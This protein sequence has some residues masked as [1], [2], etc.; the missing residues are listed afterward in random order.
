MRKHRGDIGGALLVSA[1]ACV[2]AA[3][4]LAA[5]HDPTW[6]WIALA[7]VGATCLGLALTAF[8]G[9]TDLAGATRRVAAWAR[10]IPGRVADWNPIVL[11]NPIVWRGFGRRPNARVRHATYGA[12]PQQQVVITA[13]IRELAQS[14]EPFT[15]DN[16]TLVGGVEHDPAPGVKKTLE[17]SYQR[18]SR[19]RWGTTVLTFTEGD[20]VNLP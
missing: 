18:R 11:R 19:L 13:R 4:P 10:S 14:G 12:H 9:W 2:I 3:I 15:A 8:E 1:V 7:A 5:S 6:A 16:E 17:I 20:L